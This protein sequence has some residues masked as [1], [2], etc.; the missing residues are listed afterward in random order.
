MQLQTIAKTFSAS[1][2]RRDGCSGERPQAA[3]NLLG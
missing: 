3:N 1:W 2:D